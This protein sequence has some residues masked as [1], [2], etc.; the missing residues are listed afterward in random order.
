MTTDE[1]A[2]QI[3]AALSTA[4]NYAQADQILSA[5]EETHQQLFKKII[6]SLQEKIENL[7]PLNCNSLQWSIYRYTLMC[8]RKRNMQPA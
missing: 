8:L 7:S 1:H 5:A 3:I 4:T 2:L 6:P